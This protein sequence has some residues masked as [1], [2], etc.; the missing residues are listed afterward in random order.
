MRKWLLKHAFEA[1]FS[2]GV[3]FFLLLLLLLLLYCYYYIIIYLYGCGKME[4]SGS[5]YGNFSSGKDL[6][7][8][9]NLQKVFV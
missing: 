9:G 6:K 8:M 2:E 1:C 3:A 7:L 4:Q 5:R